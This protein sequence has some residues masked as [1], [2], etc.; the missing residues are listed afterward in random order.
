MSAETGHLRRGRPRIN[1]LQAAGPRR[2]ARGRRTWGALAMAVVAV[3]SWGL[4]GVGIALL[5]GWHPGIR[6]GL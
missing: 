3:L 6:V 4:A 2:V 5:L 1:L